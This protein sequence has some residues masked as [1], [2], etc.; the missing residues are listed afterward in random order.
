MVA[1]WELTVILAAALIDTIVAIYVNALR[2][3]EFDGL[4]DFPPAPVAPY[5]P[6]F[7]VRDTDDV[8]PGSKSIGGRFHRWQP[9]ELFWGGCDLWRTFQDGPW[10]WQAQARFAGKGINCGHFFSLTG[11]GARA[12]AS[13]YQLEIGRKYEAL[14]AVVRVDHIL[15]LT[16]YKGMQL[17]FSAVVKNPDFSIPFI[18]EEFVEIERGGTALTD[19]IGHWAISQGYEGILFLGARAL[20]SRESRAR[21]PEQRG[22]LWD[23]D[24]FGI[25]LKSFRQ[26]RDQLNLVVFRGRYLL[27]RIRAYRFGGQYGCHN[28]FWKMNEEDLENM[29]SA[30]LDYLR[31]GEDYQIEQRRLAFVDKI[32]YVKRR[33]LAP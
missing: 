4:F 26:S 16:S 24:L 11:V 3:T 18:A 27:T 1:T 7:V 23:Y 15:D 8:L 31:Y 22:R 17:A 6:Q 28:I 29:L 25:Y 14:E 10:K 32:E 5:I 30:N 9:V 13:A 20:P 12:E 33:W 19:R 2:A 21:M